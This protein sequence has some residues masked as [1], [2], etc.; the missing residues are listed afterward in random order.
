MTCVCN[1]CTRSPSAS[2]NA[3]PTPDSF[4]A[5][6]LI[7]GPLQLASD[8]AAS[9][10]RLCVYLTCGQGE[11]V[12]AR[13]VVERVGLY[14]CVFSLICCVQGLGMYR[15]PL[16]LSCTTMSRRKGTNFPSS[17]GRCENLYVEVRAGER[18]SGASRDLYACVCNCMALST[19]YTIM[20]CSICFR[21]AWCSR[22]LCV[23]TCIFVL[24]ASNQH[25][26]KQVLKVIASHDDGWYL[27]QNS[28]G[29]FGVVPGNYLFVSPKVCL[30]P[31]VF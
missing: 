31:F 14:P 8:S 27:V 9:G 11:H 23:R 28:H 6:P 3:V 24:T 7:K 30:L 21:I 19:S 10:V 2:G 29:A 13:V 12:R 16:R 26:T 17:L 4:D 22:H 18:F 1:T 5:L 25:S 20:V 15:E